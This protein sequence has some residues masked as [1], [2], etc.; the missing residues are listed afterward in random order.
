MLISENIKIPKDSLD[1]VMVVMR[2]VRAERRRDGCSNI[3][4]KAARDARAAWIG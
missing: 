3:D 4:K 2:K 1:V